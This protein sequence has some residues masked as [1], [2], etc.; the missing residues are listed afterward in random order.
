[1]T[2]YVLPILACLFFTPAHAGWF[3]KDTVVEQTLDKDHLVEAL[4]QGSL[5][6]WKP[7]SFGKQVV[8]GGFFS[9]GVGLIAGV[10]KIGIFAVTGIP[11]I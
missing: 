11:L 6:P 7:D 5:H 4:P 8:R 2:R 10:I 1:M 9:V 3:H